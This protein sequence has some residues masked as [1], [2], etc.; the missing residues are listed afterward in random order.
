MNAKNKFLKVFTSISFLAIVGG[1]SAIAFPLTSC[2]KNPDPARVILNQA[3]F[4][5][6]A[7]YQ[8]SQDTTIYAS[9]QP[10]TASHNIFLDLNKLA[11][12]NNNATDFIIDGSVDFGIL[13]G[14]I[15][16]VNLYG[17]NGSLINL[18]GQ[19]VNTWGILVGSTSS[20]SDTY[21]GNMH[22]D[23]S[24]TA[25]ISSNDNACGVYFEPTATG[26]IT[27]NGNFSVFDPGSSGSA[28]GVGFSS[29]VSGSITI[30]G[31]F[32]VCSDS[33]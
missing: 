25:N 26:S 22:I 29:T 33:S 10:I 21:T 20:G 13:V 4:D 5:D 23:K 3:T 16:N 19:T 8:I 9:S 7:Q 12:D 1:I 32:S 24:V 30:N 17:E 18:T 2:K 11:A 27:I 31:N 14:F 6:N 15:E 28:S